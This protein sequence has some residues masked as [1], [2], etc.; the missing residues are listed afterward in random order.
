MRWRAKFRPANCDLTSSE[1][2]SGRRER[3]VHASRMSSRSTPSSTSR[4][5]GMKLASLKQSS[6]SVTKLPGSEPPS[7]RWWTQ[8]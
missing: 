8:L 4:M 3:R 6:V 7:S 2:R 1:I 5:G